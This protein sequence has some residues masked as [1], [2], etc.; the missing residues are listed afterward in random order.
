MVVTNVVNVPRALAPGYADQAMETIASARNTTRVLGV[1]RH[2][3][4]GRDRTTRTALIT[5]S[6]PA[7]MK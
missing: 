4:T 3:N 6:T 2:R 1:V 7:R 5:A